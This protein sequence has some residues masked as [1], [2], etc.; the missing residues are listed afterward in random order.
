LQLIQI[1]ESILFDDCVLQLKDTGSRGVDA[2]FGY[3]L[4]RTQYHSLLVCNDEV[5]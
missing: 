2:I 3:G 5:V 4:L 1:K